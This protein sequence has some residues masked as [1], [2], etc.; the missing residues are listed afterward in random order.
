LTVLLEYDDNNINRSDGVCVAGRKGCDGYD[1]RIVE[2]PSTV[3]HKDATGRLPIHVFMLRNTCPICLRILLN[4]MLGCKTKKASPTITSRNSILRLGLDAWKRQLLRGLIGAMDG[5]DLHE[6]DFTTR[7]KLD[8]ICIELRV[9]YE[10]CIA[11]E[12]VA[13]NI[14]C[15]KGWQEERIGRE[16]PAEFDDIDDSS[17]RKHRRIVS[18]AEIIVPNVIS[19]LE[20]EPVEKI[21]ERFRSYGYLR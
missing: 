7:D 13:W 19:F 15:I 6:R 8:L 17:F 20:D 1:N 5:D 10:T 2:K 16:I 9:L 18:G 21:L 4:A 14:S 12:L 11:L 3:L